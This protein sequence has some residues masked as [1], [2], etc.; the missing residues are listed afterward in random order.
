MHRPPGFLG[1]LH[2]RPFV[3]L[4]AGLLLVH[5]TSCY[6]YH[7]WTISPPKVTDPMTFDYRGDTVTLHRPFLEGDEALLGWQGG[8]Q[9]KFMVV[10]GIRVANR[11]G[12]DMPTWTGYEALDSALI[13]LPLKGRERGELRAGATALAVAGVA[14]IVGGALYALGQIFM[15]DF[16]VGW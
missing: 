13:R 1:R 15:G 8:A 10:S 5:T 6:S 7:P 11:P 3:R 14:G 9:Y 2:R 16:S 4:V 12:G